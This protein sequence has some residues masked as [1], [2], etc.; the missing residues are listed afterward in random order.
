MVEQKKIHILLVDDRPENLLSI[1]AIIEK[2]EYNLIKASSGEEAL[3]YLLKY[4]IALILLDVQM[5]GMDGFTTAKIIKARE[6][7][8][9]IPILFITANNMESEHI[10]MG[11]SV[12]A[13]DYILKPVDPLIL[14]AKVE[15]FVAFYKMK[16][17][18]IQQADILTVRT[19]ELEKSNAELSKITSKLQLSE[20]LAN[21]INETSKDAMIIFD[22]EGIMM[23]T[24]PAVGEILHYD[25]SNL[26]GQPIN[27]LFTQNESKEYMENTLKSINRIGRLAGD[28]KEIYIT[29]NDGT[30]LLAEVQIGLKFIQDT[31]IAACTIRD[32]TQQKKD[33]ELIR[34]M[35][36]HDNLTGLPNRRSLYKRAVNLLEEAKNNNQSLGVLFL[37][38][39]RFKYVNDSLGHAI[40]DL[41]LKEI[42]ALL[43][44]NI[45]KDDFATRIGG[46]EFSIILPDTDRETSLAI[47]DKILRAFQQPII[48]N[49]YEL[50]MTTSIGLSMFP[51]DG[52]D[53]PELLK[54]ADAALYRAKEQGK[55]KYKVFH[56]GMNMQSYRS[57]MMQ[58]DLR[59][60][61]DRN[62]LELSFQPRVN[63]ETGKVESA[64][65][66]IR[67]NHPSW[68]IISPAEFIPLAE[69]S[70]QIDGIGEW[71]IQAVCNQLNMWKEKRLTPIRI[72]VNFSPKQF[73]QRDLIENIQAIVHETAIES[74]LLEIEITESVLMNDK[75][76]TMN[77]LQRLKDMG[78]IISIDDFGTGYSSLD[79]LRRMPA[80]ILKIDKTFINGIADETNENRSIIIAILSLA[81]TLNMTVIAEGVETVEQLQFLRSHPCDEVQ[82]YLFSPPVP[83]SKMEEIIIQD[84]YNLDLYKDKNHSL[85]LS[86]ASANNQEQPERNNIVMNAVARIKEIYSLSS[87]E[88]EVFDLILSG[89]SNKEISQELFISEHTVKNHI[90]HIFQKLNVTDRAQAMAMVYQCCVNGGESFI[91]S[92]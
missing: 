61:I 33:E 77:T 91:Q 13:I 85:L 27:M 20:A 70:G 59:K 62:E 30:F 89:Y 4:E 55:N 24:N 32:I 81:K 45:R 68:G 40:G 26:Q 46:D 42:A 14:K 53:F 2:D 38:M 72:A 65:A 67:W 48:V 23:K 25:E 34:H 28:P 44:A 60:A 92:K 22:Q 52:E 11:Y 19:S 18:L 90:S 6:K 74:H 47:A 50:Y 3:K 54:N 39:D 63:L 5:P 15:G 83:S 36:Y 21:V 66:L 82:G 17:Q 87:R 57:F 12:G 49:H 7:T 29:R 84:G 71:V 56:T 75:D 41:V 80:H 1:E 58:N 73:L 69:V 9:N 79:Y 31:Y 8:K 51:F 35:A 16:Q 76:T 78:F 10:F 86:N 64:E 88:L 37:D 43:N